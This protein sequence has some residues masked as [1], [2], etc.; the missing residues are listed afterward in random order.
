MRPPAWSLLVVAGVL[1]TAAATVVKT[2]DIDKAPAW[3]LLG[4]STTL[5]G[6]WAALEIVKT[7]HEIHEKKKK[8]EVEE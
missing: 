4:V 7:W 6:E 2:I 5:I 8:G 3:Y 1:L